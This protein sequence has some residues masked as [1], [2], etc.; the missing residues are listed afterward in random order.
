MTNQI[1]IDELNN[2]A[3]NINTKKEEILKLYDTNIKSVL[4]ASKDAIVVSGLDFEEFVNKF[5]KTFNALSEKLGSLSDVIVNKI[6]PNY[7]N[8]GGE[9]KNAFN[10]SFAS[11]MSEI[12]SQLQ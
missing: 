10:N 9:I 3:T 4:E 5:N 1:D 2:I 11:E 8:L 12:L 6:I 7:E